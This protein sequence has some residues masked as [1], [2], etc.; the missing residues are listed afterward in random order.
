MVNSV[1]KLKTCK[2]VRGLNV[3]GWCRLFQVREKLYEL[4]VNCIPPEVILKVSH[5]LFDFI[6]CLF[7]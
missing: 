1:L 7:E 5:V 3:A 2:L 6:S 4:L